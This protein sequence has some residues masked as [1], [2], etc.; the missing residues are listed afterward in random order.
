MLGSAA[1]IILKFKVARYHGLT[2]RQVCVDIPDEQSG[3]GVYDHPK[4]EAVDS[5][6]I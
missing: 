4:A 3:N 5:P 6:R 2:M 1:M